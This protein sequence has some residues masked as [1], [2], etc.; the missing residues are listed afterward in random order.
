MKALDRRFLEIAPLGAVITLCLSV[1][2]AG[3]AVAQAVLLAHVLAQGFTSHAVTLVPL[4]LVLGARVLAGAL[5]DLVSRRTAARVKHELRTRVLRHIADLGPRWLSGQRSGE[6][7]TLMGAGTEQVDAFFAQYLPQLV[8]AVCVPLA[9]LVSLA[10]IDWPSAVVVFVTLPLLPLFLSLVGRHTRVQTARQWRRLVELGGHFLDVVQG[11]PT[12]RIFGRAQAQ[13]TVLRRLTDE[14]RLA[15]VRTLRTAF[16][17]ALVLELVA[18]LSV[19]VLAVSVAFRLLRG[20]LDL[21]RSLVVLLLAPEAFLPL[22][23]VG[24]AF[25][26]ALAGVTAA[27]SA[28]EVIEQAAAVPYR[29][30]CVPSTRRIVLDGVGVHADGRA[31][32]DHL[33][34][35]VAEGET[36]VLQGPSGSGKSTVLALLLGLAVPTSGC[37]VVDGVDLRD[38]DL[39]L[40][41]AQV[42]WVPQVPHLFA[43]SVADNIRLG[44]PGATDEQVRRAA[45]DACALAFVEALPEGFDTVLG[46]GGAGLSVG[47]SRRVAVARALLGDAPL[48][49]LDEPTAGLDPDTEEQLAR[50]LDQSCRGRT[51]I[52]ATHRPGL[53][54]ARHR[55]VTLHQ[56][57]L[58]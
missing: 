43:T 40:W 51:V 39:D 27:G 9:V 2:R 22:R 18:T 49:L 46:E 36:V 55:V 1:A 11:L 20:D 54:S 50:T 52:L 45:R 28:F 56:S 19:A 32:L 58:A 17:S 34:L 30:S 21:E 25:H 29:G 16:L 14:H 33:D 41:R 53:L 4:A 23:A 15:T 47:Q 31:G 35:A 5:Q 13:V 10:R 44:R 48:L 7:A 3:L 42:A 8:L 26:A 12:L 57:A 24:T 37:V 6:L 38:V